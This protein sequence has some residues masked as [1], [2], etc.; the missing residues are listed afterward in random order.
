MKKIKEKKD[1]ENLAIGERIILE[2]G[3]KTEGIFGGITDKKNILIVT[4]F[5]VSKKIIT[6]IPKIKYANYFDY[7]YN[8]YSLA[9]F[10]EIKR[11]NL[12]CAGCSKGNRSFI[13]D[14]EYIFEEEMKKIREN[15]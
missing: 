9:D 1:L 7:S 5:E 12:F 8:T 15:N 4:S 14:S 6:L 13:K 10:V 2:A 11:L 3:E